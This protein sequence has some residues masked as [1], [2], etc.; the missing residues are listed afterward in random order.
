MTGKSYPN[1]NVIE[2]GKAIYAFLH[3]DGRLQFSK[4][5]SLD[6]QDQR[7]VDKL[8]LPSFVTDLF[9]AL[10]GL[11]LERSYPLFVVPDPEQV[12]MTDAHA[13]Q[14]I[15]SQINWAASGHLGAMVYGEALKHFG[16]TDH[17]AAAWEEVKGWAAQNPHYTSYRLQ[18]V[19]GQG[20]RFDEAKIRLEEALQALDRPI[21]S[22]QAETL[23]HIEALP[24]ILKQ[25]TVLNAS[26][27]ITTTESHVAYNLPHSVMQGLQRGVKGLQSLVNGNLHTSFGNIEKLH[28]FSVL[29]EE[30]THRLDTMLGRTNKKDRFSSRPS[31]MEA[32]EQWRTHVMHAEL[33]GFP[34]QY[35]HGGVLSGE[36][37]QYFGGKA[38]AHGGYTLHAFPTEILADMSVMEHHPASIGKNIQRVLASGQRLSAL[39]EA[40]RPFVEGLLQADPQA[41]TAAMEALYGQALMQEYAL[42]KQQALSVTPFPRPEQPELPP[43]ANNRQTPLLPEDAALIVQAKQA[44]FKAPVLEGVVIR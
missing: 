5:P 12:D 30:L 2:H 31:F 29:V 36:Y 19:E 43:Q 14:I 44:S 25:E 6:I 11:H 9:P 26:P 23:K 15:Q 28:P 21:G 4:E 3:T 34:V 18:N 22:A 42:F 1:Y 10:A 24:D 32:L 35:P 16:N 38:Y 13:I 39:S 37:R 8:R 20:I 33:K 7:L 17:I 27:I 41:V 40:L